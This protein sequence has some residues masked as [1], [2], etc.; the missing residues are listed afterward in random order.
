MASKNVLTQAI[1]TLVAANIELLKKS[2]STDDEAKKEMLHKKITKN[3]SMILDYK[4]R[5]QYGIDG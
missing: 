2:Q 1:N 3:Q 5:L 4:F